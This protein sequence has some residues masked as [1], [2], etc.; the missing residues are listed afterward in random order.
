VVSNGGRKKTGSGVCLYTHHSHTNA[1]QVSCSLIGAF[2]DSVASRG[3]GVSEV[4]CIIGVLHPKR[5]GTA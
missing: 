5:G 2:V 1:A 3:V 4:K